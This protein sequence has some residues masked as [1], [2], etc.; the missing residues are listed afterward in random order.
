MEWF[1]HYLKGEPAKPT[2]IYTNV[3]QEE[4]DPNSLPENL[5]VT[6]KSS[7]PET[8][9]SVLHA[10]ILAW[11]VENYLVASGKLS[12]FFPVDTQLVAMIH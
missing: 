10:K 5:R 9:F 7:R 8:G 12:M 2:E 11:F 6:C 4:K 3:L 1:S